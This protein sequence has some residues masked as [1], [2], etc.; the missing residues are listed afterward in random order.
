MVES[1][2]GMIH[3]RRV[4]LFFA[5]LWGIDFSGVHRFSI[6]DAWDVAKIIHPKEG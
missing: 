2:A 1:E 4:R 3:V 6:R 5:L